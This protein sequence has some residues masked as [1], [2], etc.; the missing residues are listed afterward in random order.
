M[1]ASRAIKGILSTGAICLAGLV[2][3]WAG[4]SLSSTEARPLQREEKG[5]ERKYQNAAACAD[6]HVQPNGN[7]YP[8]GNPRS[9]KPLNLVLLTEYSIWKT[10][11][12]HAQ[13]YAVLLGPRGKSM[14][15]LLDVEDVT[16][17]EVGCVNC[18]GM[19]NLALH[20]DEGGLNLKDGVSCGGCHGP[21]LGWVKDHADPSWRKLSPAEK[22]ARGL[23]DLR[24][25]EKRAALCTSC[26]VGSPSEGK[27]VTH[28]MFAA[29]HPPLPSFEV[30]TFSRNQ[31]PHW[32][33]ARDVPYFQKPSEEDVKNFHLEDV[34][35]QRTKLALVGSVV[36]LRQTMNL[37]R[38]RA[39]FKAPNPRE[40]WPELLFGQEAAKVP[41]DAL[42]RKEAPSRWPELAMAH[43]DCFACHHDLKYPGYRQERG[44]GYFLPGREPI[45]AVP[46]RPLVRVWPTALPEA[47]AVFAGRPESV[48]SL[49]KRL[50][51]L[52]AA[53]GKKPFGSPAELRVAATEL[54][55]WC[56]EL[57]GALKKTRFTP[58]STLNLIRI[59]CN[60]YSDL[61]AKS[62]FE[63][64]LD[65]ESARQVASL[66]QV[67]FDEWKRSGRKATSEAESILAEL[68]DP[69]NLRPYN[70]RDKRLEIVFQI[71]QKTSKDLTKKEMEAF[72]AYLRN[73]G[74]VDAIRNASGFL[75]AVRGMDN[76]VFNNGLAKDHVEALQDLGNAEEKRTL[77]AVANYDPV[78]FRK[79]L[80]R[81]AK[82]LPPPAK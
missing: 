39:D 15:K 31:P 40:V 14:G 2:S 38:E 73:P 47:C 64:A 46:G 28:A 23:T 7:Q 5:K 79:Q 77:K 70:E 29:G 43:S 57:L 16:K 67:A 34:D 71:V 8:D 17:S 62:S 60:E 54:A 12:K 81:L 69:L 72:K 53:C 74:S 49:Q 82:E 56:D 48:N 41:D 76:D 6:C 61:G 1:P 10:H 35:F 25:P 51:S 3:P 33:E 9:T 80:R 26:H 21:S 68:T 22:E 36:A 59:L 4:P 20:A 44:F 11:D 63:G 78:A 24:D 37:V 52:A 30:A 19:S 65:Y 27:V 32:R 58:E 55:Q 13:A 18:H 42:L 75:N 50:T 66:L 45:R